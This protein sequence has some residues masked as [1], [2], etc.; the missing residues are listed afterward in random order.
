MARSST[1]LALLRGINV[2]G[3]NKLP[4]ADLRALFATLGCEEVRTYIQS[5]NVVFQAKGELAKQLPHAAAAAINAEF[6]YEVPVLVRS[7][8]VWSKLAASH[9]L[10]RAHDD[11]KNLHLVLLARKASASKQALLADNPSPEDSYLFRGS[12]LFLRY[13]RGPSQ[14]KLT[15]A[16]IERRLGMPTTARNW[17]TVQKLAEMIRL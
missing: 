16:W 17:R 10:A 4:M 11:P 2:G 3:K 8:R 9:P 5:G 12:E 15:G 13:T 7:A 6:G 14:S 1:Y